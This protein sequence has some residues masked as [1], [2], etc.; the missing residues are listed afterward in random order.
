[1][2]GVGTSYGAR[3]YQQWKANST[4]QKAQYRTINNKP[5]EKVTLP[6]V[7]QGL[8]EWTKEQRADYLSTHDANGDGK[9]QV[10]EYTARLAADTTKDIPAQI[11]PLVQQLMQEEGLSKE[12]ATYVASTE[13]YQ[14][15]LADKELQ[16]PDNAVVQLANAPVD[17]KNPLSVEIHRKLDGTER[18]VRN[19]FAG[20]SADFIQEKVDEYRNF[21]IKSIIKEDLGNEGYDAL[22]AQ[23]KELNEKNFA[24]YFQQKFSDEIAK[25]IAEHIA[26]SYDI[27]GDGE[28]SALEDM[29][30]IANMDATIMTDPEYGA[31]DE[32]INGR[33]TDR[34]INLAMSK[35]QMND[36][37]HNRGTLK[38][39]ENFIK[40]NADAQKIENFIVGKD[41]APELGTQNIEP[42]KT[43]VAYNDDPKQNREITATILL[44]CGT[45]NADGVVT[46]YNTNKNDIAKILDEKCTFTSSEQREKAIRLYQLYMALLNSKLE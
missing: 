31:A 22:V 4:D 35:I 37:E 36:V 5:D 30:A 1:M 20:Q 46:S 42:D 34:G 13:F 12:E 26:Q 28:I 41:N 8:A 43:K 7:F 21:A 38:T 44:L 39:F 19:R 17:P 24:E 2:S 27:N 25:P 3:A 29:S 23:G 6:Q 40:E 10:S 33:L 45:H 32:S 9:L 11:E 15:T 18:L 16:N 14:E